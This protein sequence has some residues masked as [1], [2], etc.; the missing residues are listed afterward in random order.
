MAN[1]LVEAKR[2]AGPE[3]LNVTMVIP[4]ILTVA[5]V[6]LVVY[7]RGRKK[8]TLVAEGVR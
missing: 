2:A 5:F 8:E 4:I 1:H 6:G 7:M 3:I